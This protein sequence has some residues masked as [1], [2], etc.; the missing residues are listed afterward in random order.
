[1][2]KLIIRVEIGD[3]RRMVL[4]MSTLLNNSPEGYNCLLDWA[5]CS[6]AE[7]VMSCVADICF[8]RLC[9]DLHTLPQVWQ[10][11]CFGWEVSVE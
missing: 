9:N 8:V 4:D 3:F 11:N 5:S 2:G 1:M 7:E 10:V 6:D